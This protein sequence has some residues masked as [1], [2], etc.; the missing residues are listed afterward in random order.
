VKDG[1]DLERFR[2]GAIYDQIRIDGE[3]LHVLVRQILAEVPC[4][5]S[6]CE[7]RNSFADGRFNAVCNRDAC[8]LFNV[9]LDFD[10]VECGLGRKN[11]AHAHLDLAFQFRQVCIQLIFRDSFATIELLDPAP[12]L[13]VDCFPVLQKPTVLFFL[14]LQ[15]TE[16]YF[17]DAAGAGRLKLFLDSGL[18]GRILDFEVHELTLQKRIGLSFKHI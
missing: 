1:D 16:Q 8:L 6:S 18:N 5:G 9:T 13:C 7:K 11:V 12:D 15:Q 2:L 17:L 10:E 3:K 4:A 14:S